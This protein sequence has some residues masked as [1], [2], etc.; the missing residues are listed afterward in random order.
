MKI[1]AF[2]IPKQIV[3]PGLVV[4]VKRVKPA[5]PGEPGP[6]SKEA[7]F[8]YSASDGTWVIRLADDLTIAEARY[9]LIHELQHVM[10]DF[11]HVAILKHQD[12]FKII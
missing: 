9:S 8:D 2:R 5:L 4:Q 7:D 1:V 11:L 6:E 3:L 12:L 10:T